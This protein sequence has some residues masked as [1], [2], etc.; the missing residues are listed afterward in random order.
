MNA[1]LCLGIN[2][3]EWVTGENYEYINRSSLKA[4]V[5]SFMLMGDAAICCDSRWGHLSLPFI[6]SLWI[7]YQAQNTDLQTHGSRGQVRGLFSQHLWSNSKAILRCWDTWLLGS[8]STSQASYK[9]HPQTKQTNE[10]RGLGK[11]ICG[12]FLL[13]GEQFY[14]EPMYI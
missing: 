13:F 8:N 11:G 10:Q 2:D 4:A 14:D 5:T 7:L 12:S 9:Q 6:V 3:F 1:A